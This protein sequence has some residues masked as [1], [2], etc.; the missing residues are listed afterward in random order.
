PRDILDN[1]Y[2]LAYWMTENEHASAELVKT[3][4]SNA[5]NCSQE[6][7]LL[8]SFRDSYVK[9]YGQDSDLYM[10]ESA[11]GTDKSLRETIRQKAADVKLSVLLSEISGLKHRQ[12]SEIMEKPVET[13]RLWLL[14]GRKSLVNEPLLKASA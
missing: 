6:T 13:I 14:W 11:P 2:S 12:I 1:I 7:D 3:T 10:K 5:A 9:R 8:K 4:Y